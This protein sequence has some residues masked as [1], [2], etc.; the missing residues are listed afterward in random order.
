MRILVYNWR[1][2]E[3]PEAGGA[4][5]YVHEVAR[6]WVQ[7][8]HRVIVLCSHPK[9]YPR[10][11]VRDG[12]VY[13]RRGGRYSLYGWAVLLYAIR[14]GRWCDVVMDCENG[15]PFFSPLFSR[16]RV[17]GVVHHV[18]AE[19]F[20]MELPFPLNWIGYGLETWIMPRV[21]RT[22]SMVAVSESTREA[23]LRLGFRRD[24]ITIAYNGVSDI[25]FES[26]RRYPRSPYPRILYLGRLKRY[27]RLNLLIEA[28]REI[29]KKIPGV[30][31]EIVGRGDEEKNLKRLV[32]K[33]DLNPHVRFLGY[34]SEEEKIRRLST[35]WVFATPS[36]NEGWGIAVLEAAACGTP[37]VAF[38]VPGLSCSIRHGE[39]GILV[40]EGEFDAFTEALRTLLEDETERSRLGQ[41]AKRWARHFHWDRTADRLLALMEGKSP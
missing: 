39:T 24:R 22:A 33:L 38:D 27:K 19:Q 31:L 1:D 41:Q 12:V 18:H 9:G 25:F 13:V 15:I 32:R 11:M 7:R 3:H 34:V 17:I 20:F 16:K 30:V 35:A 6:R 14:Y 40:P 37:A 26:E 23:M 36:L 5:T 10:R 8:G 2:P 28:V 21:Y 4:E 29:S